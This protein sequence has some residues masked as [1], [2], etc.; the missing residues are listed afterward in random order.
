MGYW[1][2][3][4]EKLQCRTKERLWK[5]TTLLKRT[6]YLGSTRGT[7]TTWKQYCLTTPMIRNNML[8]IE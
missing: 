7:G 3:G 6:L 5:T 2:N 8:L 4:A 1:R